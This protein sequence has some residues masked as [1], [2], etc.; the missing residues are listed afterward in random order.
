MT[1][2]QWREAEYRLIAYGYADFLIDEYKVT[3][4]RSQRS[5]TQSVL[6]P[7]IDGEYHISWLHEDCEIRRRFFPKTVKGKMTAKERSRAV[8]ELGA[9]GF[10]E[11]Q[12]LYPRLVDGIETY[13]PYFT[14][15]KTLRATF[16]ANNSSIEL[17]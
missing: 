1:Q 17:I 12:K 2:E 7:Y 9:A 6:M 10:R 14:S 16:T 5:A 4:F 15:F 8:K 11:V 13:N 3:V